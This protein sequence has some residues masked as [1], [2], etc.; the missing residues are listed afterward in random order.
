MTTDSARA[1]TVAAS[2]GK[3]PRSGSVTLRQVAAAAG[4][5]RATASRVINGSPLASEHARQA[6]EAA[7]AELGFTPS[8]AAR[9]LALGRTNSV[10]LVLPEPN[11]RV[12]TDPFFSQVILGLSAELETTDL[13]MVL[14]LA[15][16]GQRT[17]RIDR[18][19]AGRHVDG[20][21][22]ASH[23]RDD[24][25][26]Q[27]LVDSGLPCVFLGRP[28]A[29]TGAHYVDMDNA[30]GARLATRHLIDQGRRHI[31][32]ITGPQ[33]MTAGID[34]VDGW[35]AALEAA[36]LSD[37][38]IEVGNFTEA[39]GAAAMRGL[40]ATHP[41]IDGVFVASDIMAAGALTVLAEHGRRVPEDVAVVGFD[42]F[43][44]AGTTK[45]PLTTVAQPVQAMT[46]QA[47]RL[48]LAMMNGDDAGPDPVIFPPQL[49]LRSSA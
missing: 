12:L 26:N 45:P 20:A 21:V 43:P 16:D 38:G 8:P 49:V 15:R 42:D 5:S 46:A 4:V 30:S 32:T 6:V 2:V 25:L 22:I 27:R 37:A 48:L 19:L 24:T 35:R 47:G 28:L 1:S 7:I 41:E 29:V 14:L 44:I 36:G 23:H 39:A 11:A 3:R 31:A 34:R 18:Y 40:L 33:D 13:Q 10:A 17:E 9:S